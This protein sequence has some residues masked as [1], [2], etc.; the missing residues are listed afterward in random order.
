MYFI[1]DFTLFIN[2]RLLQKQCCALSV[3]VEEFTYVN[4]NVHLNLVVIKFVT[5]LL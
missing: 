2:T 1:L 4:I 3:V 5:H